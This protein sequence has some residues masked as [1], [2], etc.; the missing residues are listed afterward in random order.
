MILLPRSTVLCR[1][2]PDVS[3]DEPFWFGIGR[4]GCQSY[5]GIGRPLRLYRVANEAV[6][7]NLNSDETLDR[8]EERLGHIP[9]VGRAIRVYRDKS[10][11]AY[12]LPATD[13][14][15]AK[16]VCSHRELFSGY[17]GMYFGA[18]GGLPQEV[19]LCNP[20]SVVVDITP[21]YMKSY[22]HPNLS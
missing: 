20:L 22:V 3:N 4:R 10:E 7:I 5:A 17:D 19:M 6:L 8:L 21:K 12:H 16:F 18:H 13:I 11:W 2:G 9:L 15:F 1:Y 14:E